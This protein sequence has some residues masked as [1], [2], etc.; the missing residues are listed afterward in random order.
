[1]KLPTTFVAAS[2][3]LVAIGCALHHPLGPTD[4]GWPE[5][6]PLGCPRDAGTECVRQKLHDGVRGFDNDGG[7]R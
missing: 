7:V 1:M 3:V 2:V 5:E 4:P 6:S